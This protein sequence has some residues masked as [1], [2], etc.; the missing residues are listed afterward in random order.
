MEASVEESV[1]RLR[2]ESLDLLLL[3][4][5]A[6]DDLSS[7]EL[8]DV[9]DG[10]RARG[11]TRFTGASVYGQQAALAAIHSGR[12]D[13]LQIAWNLLDRRAGAGAAGVPA[14]AEFRVVGGLVFLPGAC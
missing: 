3:H 8:A 11:L 5:S 13:C 9:L 4:S 1:R 14:P 6:S 10:I 12:F 2:T 7:G